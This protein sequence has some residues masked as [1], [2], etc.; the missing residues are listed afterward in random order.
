MQVKDLTQR[1]LTFS[2][3]GTPILQTSD[4]GRLLRECADLALSGSNVRGE[5]SMPDDLWPAEIDTGQINQVISNLIINANQ[6]MPNGGLIK[7]NAE[8][9]EIEAEHGLPLSPGSYVRISILDQGIGI[10][11]KHLQRVFDPFFTT[12]QKGSGLGLAIAFSIIKQHNG[13]ITVETEPITGEGKILVMDDEAHIRDLA[14]EM[15]SRC[16]YR[17]VTAVEGAEAIELYKKA[18][19]SDT[20]FDAVI[21]DLTVPGGMGGKETIQRLIEIDPDV[22]AIVSSGYSNDPVM[23]NF[24][25][26]GFKGV[27]AKPYKLMELSKVMHKVITGNAS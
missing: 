4:V 10:A 16:G 9:V 11:K 14:T 26:H 6:A 19:G 15:L 7:V 1:L 24:R 23:A 17:V 22:K 5:F 20:P 8:N 27:I 18:M 21:T 12:K 3:G 25:E 13:Y 2:R